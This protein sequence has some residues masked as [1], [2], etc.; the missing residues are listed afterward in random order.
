MAAFPP[1]QLDIVGILG[2]GIVADDGAIAL[3]E[4]STSAGRRG[5]RGH[6]FLNDWYI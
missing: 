3:G 5:R 1:P 6:V 4:K 2:A